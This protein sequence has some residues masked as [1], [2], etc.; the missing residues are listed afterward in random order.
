MRIIQVCVAPIEN[1][2]D[3]LRW[4]FGAAECRIFVRTPLAPCKSFGNRRRS[5]HKA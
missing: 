4:N 3:V 5:A 1:A 2:E